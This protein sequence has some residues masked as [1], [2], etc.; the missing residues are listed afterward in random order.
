MDGDYKGR[1]G[2]SP[3]GSDGR[4]IVDDER[5]GGGAHYIACAQV[6]ARWLAS[7]ADTLGLPV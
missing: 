5:R 1:A 3:N 7:F 4:I 2:A 6:S